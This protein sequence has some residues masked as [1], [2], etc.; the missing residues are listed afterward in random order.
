MAGDINDFIRDIVE[1]EALHASM[2]KGIAK[3]LVE[4][5]AARGYTFTEADVNAHMEEFADHY[6]E[7]ASRAAT[8]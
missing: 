5:G 8:R 2:R 7:I 6:K 3:R 1:D 4:Y